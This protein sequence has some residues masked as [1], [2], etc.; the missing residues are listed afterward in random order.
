MEV[1]TTFN[2]ATKPGAI[3]GEIFKQAQAVYAETGFTDEWKLHHQGGPTG[4]QGRFFKATPETKSIV[5]AGHVV[6]WNPSITGTKSEDT[7]LIKPDGHEILTA[8]IDW[9]TQTVETP[10]GSMQRCQILV[11]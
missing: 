1:D 6:A 8:A 9:P 4:Y 11:R 5:S 10:L 7:V 3:Y 2:L